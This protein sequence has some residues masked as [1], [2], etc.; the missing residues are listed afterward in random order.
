MDALLAYDWP[1]NIRELRNVLERSAILCSGTT[2]TVM[3][4]LGDVEFRDRKPARSLKQNLEEVERTSILRALE[5]SGWKVRGEGNAAD[6]L[7]I[8]PNTLRSR[9]KKLGISRP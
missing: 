7:G 2:L 5:E 4:A 1:G 9:M 8:N 6:R 3:E